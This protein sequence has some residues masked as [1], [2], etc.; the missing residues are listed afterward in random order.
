M[1]TKEIDWAA[2]KWCEGYTH[3]EIAKALCASAAS[4]S[5]Y[6]RKRN[7]SRK[8]HLKKPDEPLVYHR[9]GA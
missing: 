6:L 5:F 9:N 1:T 8:P 3:R 4:V 2:E 7:L